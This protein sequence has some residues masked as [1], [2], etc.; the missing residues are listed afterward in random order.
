MAIAHT[1]GQAR[2]GDARENLKQFGIVFIQYFM[3]ILI[4]IIMINLIISFLI[5]NSCSSSG[6]NNI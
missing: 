4:N 5:K 3:N 6:N 1:D 2:R